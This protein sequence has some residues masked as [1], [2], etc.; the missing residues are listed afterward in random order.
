M[1]C[2]LTLANIERAGDHVVV[3][4]VLVVVTAIGGLVYGLVRLAGKRRAARTRS[5]RAAV[6]DRISGV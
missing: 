2:G 4:G 6:D 1:S 5:D 3:L